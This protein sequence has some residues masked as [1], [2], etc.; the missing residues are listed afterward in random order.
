ME[1]IGRFKRFF[2]SMQDT[3]PGMT[4][5]NELAWRYADGN[6]PSRTSDLTQLFIEEL[7]RK[8]EACQNSNKELAGE[9]E[10]ARTV[11][12]ELRDKLE[13]AQV[14]M[15]QSEGLSALPTP[16]PLN[17]L[18]MVPR[19]PEDQRTPLV[20]RLLET[21]ALLKEQ[22]QGLKDE[23][24]RLKG[25]KP[26]PQLRP[27]KLSRSDTPGETGKSEKEGNGKRPGS[28]KKPKTAQLEIHETIVCQ[29][30]GIPEGSRFKGYED[31]TVQDV[32]IVAHN[33][34]YRLARWVAPD[35]TSHT[36]KPPEYLQGS[37]F[38]PELVGFVLYQYHHGRVTQPL[39]LEQLWEIGVDISAGQLNNLITEGLAAFHDEKDSLLSTGLE[40]SSYIHVDDTGA[41]HQG[42]NGYC[43]HVGNELFT[44]FESTYSKSRLNFLQILRG[45]HTDYV[46]CE[47]ALTYMEEYKLPKSLLKCLRAL[48]QKTFVDSTEWQAAL[49]SLGVTSP[50][51]V[52]TVTEGALL[53]S[54]LAH[55]INP[56]LVIMSDDA[57]QFN[58]LIHTLCWIHA[59]RTLAKLVGFSDEQRAAL[60]QIR[61]QVW[62][63]Y[64]DLKVYKANPTPEHKQELA[65]RFD[66]L[67]STKT[68]FATLNQALMRLSKNKEELLLVLER[69][70]IPL[71]NNLSESDIREY[72]T[73]RKISGSTRSE[74]GRRS[75]DTFASLKKTC[76]KHGI[77]FWKYLQ[78]RLRL[79][80]EIPPLSELIRQKAQASQTHRSPADQKAA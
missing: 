48:E 49:V 39:L 6:A 72:V 9:L 12:R 22:V 45:Q 13:A 24:A 28:A 56:D 76:R 32:I 38:G 63:Y 10:N 70:E 15:Q 57:G 11:N 2:S 53:G 59:E 47:L 42:Q 73:K 74:K 69:P 77:S 1:L 65:I 67:F 79:K 54:A 27:S 14:R 46:V 3:L 40:V 5:H 29:P 52:Q 75:R 68:C 58:V 30:E 26:K 50:R 41:R 35:G 64:D 21:I 78:D 23:M 33:T 55:G 18:P 43:T 17:V 37:H 51:H 8:L 61:T 25:L 66:E 20:A 31:Y 80:H 7:T 4:P 71:Q 16:E 60:E 34:L 36:G 44:Y 62:A 19:V